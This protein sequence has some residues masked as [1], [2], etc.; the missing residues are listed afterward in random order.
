MK[1]LRYALGGFL[2]LL[3]LVVALLGGAWVWTGSTTS[4]ATVLNR[5]IPYLPEGQTLTASDVS[6]SLRGGGRIGSLTWRMG[7]LTVE[8]EEVEVGW[9]LLPL[10]DGE[11]RISQLKAKRLRIDD[12]RPAQPAQDKTPPT[13]FS[14][15]IQ[16][17]VPF[18]IDTVEWAGPPALVAT[19]LNGKYQF[20]SKQHSLD[21]G[22]VHISSGSYAL[23]ANIEALAPM[24]VEATLDGTVT[25]AVPGSD[26]SVTVTA[27]ARVTGDLSPADAVLSL[28]AELLPTLTGQPDAN[29][30]ATL[31]AQLMPWKAQPLAQAQASWQSL[32][33]AALWPQAPMTDLSGE[34]QVT[35]EGAG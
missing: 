14:L 1:A 15:P 26:Q 30:Q 32:N 17:S 2:A 27:K 4:L 13:N 21:V 7:E 23:Q 5:A 6:G 28:Q 29:P 3:L 10:W 33:L 22:Q 24:A 20:D 34:A 25:T 16:V 8:A 19:G 11:L 12:R 35:P 9:T 31:N 18:A